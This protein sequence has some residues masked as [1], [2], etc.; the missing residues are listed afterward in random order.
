MQR[1]KGR[2][3]AAEG[4]Q[5]Q[6]KRRTKNIGGNTG[7]PD[8]VPLLYPSMQ[9]RQTSPYTEGFHPDE[10]LIDP[11]RRPNSNVT[12][13][14]QPQNTNVQRITNAQP[15]PTPVPR[16]KQAVTKDLPRSTR[17]LPEPLPT[18][19]NRMHMPKNMHWLFLVG[20]GMVVAI[21]LWQVGT[22]VLAWGIQRYNDVRYGMPRTYQTDQ[23]VGHGDSP[24]HP[25]HFMAMNLNHQA[26]VIELKGGDPAKSVSY[27][28]PLYIVGDN[29]QA[30]VTLEFRD[31]NGDHKV[32]MIIHILL[33]NQE[34][35]V[36]IND[37]DKFRP[38]NN[39][40]NIHL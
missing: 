12:R 19:T 5:S 6:P 2:A 14:T 30:P 21:L 33:P 26:V 23:V 40:D 37:G 17:K 24:A 36:F 31:V 18:Q 13:Y 39:G 22:V 16:R 3:M 38:S 25:S 27:V 11:P 7:N 15:A 28:A 20:I 10:G 4:E 8:P 9:E 32:D 35:S 1:T 29:G 34:V